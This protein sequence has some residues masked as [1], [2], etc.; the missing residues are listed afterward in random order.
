MKEKKRILKTAAAM[1]IVGSL[2]LQAQNV[3]FG[4]ER[5]TLKKAFEKIEAVSSYKIAY[6]ASKLNVNRTVKLDKKNKTVVQALED[7][8]RDT[9][10]TFEMKGNLIIIVPKKSENVKQNKST[11]RVRISGVVTDQNGEAVIGATVGEKGTTNCT[12]TDV[13]GHYKLNVQKGG[14][15]QVSYIGFITQNLKVGGTNELNVTLKEDQHNLNEVVV[16]GYG[17]MKKSDLTGAVASVT[18]DQDKAVYESGV[19]HLLQGNA[20]GV[21]VNSGDSQLGGLINVRIRGTSTLNGNKEPLYVIDGIIMNDA[22]EDAGNAVS[23]GT[24]GDPVQTTQSGLTG[25]NPQ[26]IQSIEVLKDAS[27]TAIY[28]SRASNGVVLITTKEGK[29]G[30]AKVNFSTGF[31]L[32]KA[33]KHIDVLDAEEYVIYKNE[34]SE[35]YYSDTFHP[36]SRDW[37]KEL[38]HTALTQ[39]YRLSV[40]GGN[41]KANYFVAGGYLD[42]DGIIRN[43]GLSQADLRVNYKYKLSKNMSLK[44]TFSLVRRIND[45]TAGT[46]GLGN[47]TTSLTRHAILAKPFTDVNPDDENDTGLQLMPINWLT[48]YKDHSEEN[49]AV[50]SVAFDYKIVKGLTFHLMGSYDTRDKTRSRWY[51]TGVYTGMKVK[52]QLGISELKSQKK[53]LEALLYYD[54]TINDVHHLSGTAGVTYERRDVNRYGMVGEDFSVLSLGIDGIAYANKTYTN[55]H[56]L[57]NETTASSLL[58]VNYNY[59]DRYLVTLTGRVDG[60]SKFQKNNRYSFFPS[61]ALAWRVSQ[62]NFLKDSKWLNN[63]KIRMGWG[64]TGNQGISAYATQNTYSNV[65]YSTGS[66][67]NLVGMAPDKIANPN[68]KWEATSQVN[69]G[70]DFGVLNNRLTFSI[71]AYHKETNDILQSMSTAVSTGFSSIYVNC[72]SIQNNGVEVAVNAVPITTKDF[73]WNIGANLSHNKNRIT[74][75]GLPET[76]YGTEYYQAY[77]GTN[78][79]YFGSA[80]FPVN[81]FIKGKPIGLF[82]GY[83]TNGIFQS[84]EEANGLVHNGNKLT[85]GDITYVDINHDGVINTEDRVILGDP[86]PDFTFGFNTSLTYKAFTLSAQFYGSVGNDLVNANLLDNT[87]TYYDYNILKEAYY[88]AW[89]AESPSI[90]YPKLGTPLNELTDRMVE[91]GSFLRMSS[92]SLTWNMPV[93]KWKAINGLQLT[94]TGRNLFT[95]TNY[96]GYD[97]DANSFSNDSKRVGI[98]YGSAPVTRSYSC[99]VNVT[100]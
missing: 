7:L 40:S 93:R 97:P 79:S 36:V 13:N 82:W 19:D 98:D 94:L 49:R 68:L 45:M 41:D 53:A 6:N 81:I 8:L 18:V 84:D 90:K 43:T 3:S 66:G 15:I 80:A 12:V 4:N 39:S 78:L 95:I 46:D 71:D 31:S 37:Q 99:T 26:D 75:L 22:T 23:G 34:K 5:T 55:S 74:D 54:Y 77:Y 88:E 2:S 38:Y 51:G 85:A 50:A 65:E 96:S 87:N 16:V 42:N 59:M 30:K 27:A 32:G 44:G 61:L 25:L 67:S 91:N 72:G 33:T 9:D 11:S 70:I 64:M 14:L 21:Y 29:T 73:T 52:G 10:C 62:E 83:K 24:G 17:Q 57:T 28:G 86:N 47:S 35:G 100:F 1:L 92:L 58:R 56:S 89:R 63:L 69:A 76:K 20:P 48:D 60:S